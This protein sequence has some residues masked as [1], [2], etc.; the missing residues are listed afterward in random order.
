MTKFIYNDQEHLATKVTPFFADMGRH[1]YKGTAPKMALR[2]E[3]AQEF[4]NGMRKT[5]NEVGSA[6]KMAKKDMKRFYDRKR[7]EAMEYK[8]G[9]KVWLEGTNLSTDRPMKKLDNECF[10]PFKVIKKV[11]TS[12]YKLQIPYMWKSIHL[13]FN[14]ALLMPYHKSQFLTQPRDTRSPPVLEGDKPEWEVEKVINS[15]KYQGGFQ[16][17]V[18]W[19]GYGTHK[20][21]W[22]LACN[23]KNADKAI[24][25]FH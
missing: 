12:S 19:K 17:K 21:S 25:D 3:T 23:L 13:M 16:Y 18:H 6:L 14:E 22:K 10:G 11:G 2:N 15:W 7:T 5:W 24:S 20:Q 8:E 1:P 9:D 4:A